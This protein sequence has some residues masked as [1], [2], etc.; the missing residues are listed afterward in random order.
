MLFKSEKNEESN[1]N[2]RKLINEYEGE[3][4]FDEKNEKKPEFLKEDQ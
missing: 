4:Y 2:N 1:K 3:G